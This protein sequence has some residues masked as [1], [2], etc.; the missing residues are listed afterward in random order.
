[1]KTLYININGEATPST[2][3]RIVVGKP[4]L[5]IINKF[6]F[7][8]AKEIVKG[9]NTLG[10]ENAKNKS[11][12]TDFESRDK[13]AYKEITN[14]WEYVR[15]ALLGENPTGNQTI[16]LPPEYIDWLTNHVN[17]VYNKI[18][19][20]LSSRDCTVEI[21]IEKIYTNA[22]GLL[23]NNIDTTIRYDQFVVNDNFVDDDS[24]ISK[25]IRKKIGEDVPFVPFD[26]YI[27]PVRIPEKPVRPTEEN[28]D[29]QNETKQ[30]IN[31]N[32]LEKHL[33]YNSSTRSTNSVINENWSGLFP[34]DGIILGKTDIYKIQQAGE[35]EEFD[36]GV[37][38]EIR[39]HVSV[40]QK[41]EDS[42]INE[43]IIESSDECKLPQKW[44]ELLGFPFKVHLKRCKKT[45]EKKG[46]ELNYIQYYDDGNK[47]VLGF[48]TPDKKYYVVLSGFEGYFYTIRVNLYKCPDCGSDNIIIKHGP[49]DDVST[50]C[51]SCGREWGD[52]KCIEESDKEDGDEY[53]DD[54]DELHTFF[55][56]LGITLGETTIEEV[57]SQGYL[58]EKIEHLDD[59][60]E[61]TG[62]Y[63]EDGV[64]IVWF[65]GIQIRKERNDDTL[66]N[67]YMTC[68][69]PMF[70]EWEDLGFSWELSYNEWKN[71]FVLRGY[72]IRIEEEPHKE[73]SE[74]SGWS[75]S[76]EFIA[77]APDR[78]IQFILHF[79]SGKACQQNSK[80]TLYSIKV[81]AR[82]SSSWE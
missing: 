68:Y 69:H 48:I 62:Y 9:V 26:E 72:D 22:I 49:W 38:C 64:S 56:V 54:S 12:I 17:L 79:M 45:L 66:T 28:D 63:D 19:K 34:V 15:Q 27:P 11:L 4:D 16:N 8:L 13:L 65:N 31:N 6:Y 14:Q 57:E 25:D 81:N 78:S 52:E 40:Y 60:G 1:M 82:N 36:Y 51:K 35:I 47:D 73:F 76:A 44:E 42:F 3:E 61:D 33:Q 74:N 71:L 75:L 80:K 55:P 41:E 46:I 32:D 50:L 77:C 24:K 39:K 30:D 67:I 23:V 29:S 2:E 53:A 5:A 43:I 7:E 18:A 10:I 58:F 70:S 21:S 59:D 20:S 37:K